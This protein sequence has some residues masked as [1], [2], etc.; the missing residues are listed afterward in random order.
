M[1]KTVPLEV[2]FGNKGG[3]LIMRDVQAD[4]QI[5]KS[6][7]KGNVFDTLQMLDFHCSLLWF[8]CPYSILSNQL[9][10]LQMDSKWVLSMYQSGYLITFIRFSKAQKHGMGVYIAHLWF[11][12]VSPILQPLSGCLAFLF[13]SILIIHIHSYLSLP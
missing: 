13:S 2:S 10:N 6:S 9:W 1:V 5:D 7:R 3:S 12:Q 4:G 8:S 11:C